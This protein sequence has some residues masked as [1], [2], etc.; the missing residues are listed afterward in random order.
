MELTFNDTALLNEIENWKVGQK[1][2]Q[3]SD[4]NFEIF[5]HFFGAFF[6]HLFH[7]K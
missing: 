2:F 1:N 4:Q 5:E 6:T 3:Q 7:V